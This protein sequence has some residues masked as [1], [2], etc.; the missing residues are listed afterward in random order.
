M[1]KYIKR[2]PNIKY[3][4]NTLDENKFIILT[5]II[6]SSI[7]ASTYV[8]DV[9][10]KVS[11]LVDTSF[12]KFVMFVIL[13]IVA[14]K[15][16]ALGVALT[17][18]VLV[19]LQVISNMNMKKEM[20]DITTGLI[21]KKINNESD[22]IST[23]NSINKK[24]KNNNIFIKEGFEVEPAELGDMTNE[25]YYNPV[26][27]ISE[28]N[29]SL[30]NLDLEFETP[31]Q[32]YTNMIK[33]GKILLDNSLEMEKD[34][35][36]RFDTREKQIA[37]ISK[38]DGINMIQSGLNRLEKGD[39]GEYNITDN[40][41]FNNNTNSIKK[42]VQFT[43]SVN[44][45]SNDN[46]ILQSFNNFKKEYE[47]LNT[48]IINQ[49]DFYPQLIKVY[50]AKIDLLKKIFNKTK[51]NFDQ[52]K[53]QKINELLNNLSNISNNPN[54]DLDNWISNINK[55]SNILL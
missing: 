28:L 31:T 16:P 49:S 2:N 55:L 44:K 26:Q 54:L 35:S 20:T 4:V 12:F 17:I 27:Q 5:V 50:I 15:N 46:E 1:D 22:D 30:N 37:D 23:T 47:K 19:T 33:Q 43:N 41:Q 10:D 38:R 39:L 24:D 53:S 32:L 51:D 42:Y 34:L 14:G 48:N 3:M 11:W 52:N 18:A 6:L 25:F 45:Y 29:P 40:K 7:Y 8:E 36:K 13:S 21:L 9:A